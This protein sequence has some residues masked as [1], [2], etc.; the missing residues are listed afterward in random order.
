MKK[1]KAEGS[2]FVVHEID[3]LHRVLRQKLSP[4]K[5]LAT[6][7]R[8]NVLKVFDGDGAEDEP[9]ERTGTRHSFL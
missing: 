6:E 3:R 2:V 4:D 9:V 7:R 5:K 8:L 1:I